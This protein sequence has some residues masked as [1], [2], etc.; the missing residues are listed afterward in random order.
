MKYKNINIDQN[1]DTFF[2]LFV[3]NLSI[4]DILKIAIKGNKNNN[5]IHIIVEVYH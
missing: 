2:N 3:F 1:K 4:E 5:F